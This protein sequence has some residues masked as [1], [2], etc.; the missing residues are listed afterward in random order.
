MNKQELSNA[1]LALL[2][3]YNRRM[4]QYGKDTRTYGT[5]QQLRIDQMHLLNLV[6]EHPGINLRSLAQF[7]DTNVPT[8]SLQ[9]NRLVKLGLLTKDRASASQREIVIRLTQDGEAAF[10]Y[11]KQL[12]NNFFS[13]ALAALDRYSESELEVI[14]RYMRDLEG[15]DLQGDVHP[16]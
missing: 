8:L 15:S 14:Y 10:Q 3:S 6:G 1:V 12:D 13:R 16:F 2:N 11:H 7:T 9:V 5:S 4:Y